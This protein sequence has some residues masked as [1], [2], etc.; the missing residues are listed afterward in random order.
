MSQMTVS[1]HQRNAVTPGSQAMKTIL[2][3]CV[4]G[5]KTIPHGETSQLRQAKSIAVKL[6]SSHCPDICTLLVLLYL[7]AGRYYS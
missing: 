6:T 2:V 5:K 7:H 1:K 3:L 4:C